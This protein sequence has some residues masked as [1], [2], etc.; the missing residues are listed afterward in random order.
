MAKYVQNSCNAAI[1]RPATGETL[2][3]KNRQMRHAHQDCVITKTKFHGSAM[4]SR[5]MNWSIRSM[6]ELNSW[7]KFLD[8]CQ[9]IVSRGNLRF[10]YAS[11]TY[12]GLSSSMIECELLGCLWHR[13]PTN[14]KQQGMQQQ[15]FLISTTM[16]CDCLQS[17]RCVPVLTWTIQYRSMRSMRSM[18][19]LPSI[20]A[21]IRKW[22]LKQP[23]NEIMVCW[24]K[25]YKEALLSLV[26]MSQS[27]DG[28]E[29]TLALGWYN[30]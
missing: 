17:R 28:L 20:G 18:R 4:L 9:I 8:V 30:R 13:L 15:F 7:T 3:E 12:L 22:R 2:F 16:R 24:M 25:L 23:W 1:P 6:H 5:E 19:W 27:C 21:W 26:C 29:S 10:Y 11:M 14:Q